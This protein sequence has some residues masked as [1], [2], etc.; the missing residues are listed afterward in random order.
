MPPRLLTR[1]CLGLEAQ[2]VDRHGTT[3]L[4]NVPPWAGLCLAR[5][6]WAGSA[7]LASY[8]VVCRNLAI[9]SCQ[10]INSW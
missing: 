2:H 6:A 8:V 10:M 4:L 3:R 5:L 7:R 9:C 1:P